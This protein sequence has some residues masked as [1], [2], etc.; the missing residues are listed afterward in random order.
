[1]VC[2]LFAH[3][4]PGALVVS[5]LYHP[6]VQIGLTLRAT[7]GTVLG[8]LMSALQFAVPMFFV[9]SGYLIARPWVRAYVLER[10]TPRLAPYMLHRTLRIVPVFWLLSAITLIAYQPRGGSPADLVAIFGFGQI[11]HN[12]GAGLFLG[13]AWTIDI[14][15]AFYLLVPPSAWLI[16]AA[17]R[18][19]LEA[20]GRELGL[21]GRIAVVVTLVTA[22]TVASAWLRGVTLAS[23]DWNVSPPATFYYFGPGIALAALELA[24]TSVEARRRVRHVPLVFGLGAGVITVV[25]AIAES[26]DTDAIVRSRG[27][28]AV[29][30]ASGLALGALLARQLARGDSP[31]WVDNPVTRWLGARSYPCYV[32]QTSTVAAAVLVFG[33]VSSPWVALLLLSVFTVPL[34]LLAGAI[35]HAVLEQPLLDWGHRRTRRPTPPAPPG[36]AVA[37]VGGRVDQDALVPASRGGG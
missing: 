23:V 25:L 13:Q 4:A 10:G 20:S 1:M 31:R 15:V 2:V 17:T 32:A 35:V 6:D 12:S 9:L 34:T 5:S 37:G 14:E 8:V 19:L 18:R 16:T 21:R 3:L 30:L 7:F 33:A 24:F 27:A 28:V 22:A 36:A 29:A 11:Y 26:T